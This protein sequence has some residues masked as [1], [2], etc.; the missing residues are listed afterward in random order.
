[1]SLASLDPAELSAL[2]ENALDA[3]ISIDDGGKIRFFNPAAEKLFQYSADELLGKSVNALMRDD[4]AASHDTFLDRYLATGQRSIIGVGRAVHCRR[5]DGSDFIAHIWIT[6]YDAADGKRFTAVLHDLSNRMRIIDELARIRE[7]LMLTVEN[8]PIGIVTLDIRGRV[9]SM[10]RWAARS[11]GYDRLELL[12]QDALSFMHVDDQQ[13]IRRSM[14]ALLT[15]RIDHSISTH[16]MR[17]ANRDYMPVQLYIA[18]AHDKQGR[19]RQLICM[20]EDLTRQRTAEAEL[21]M[22]RERLAHIARIDT[23]GEMAVG[24]AHEL[25]QPLAAITTYT[26]AAKRMFSDAFDDMPELGETCDKIADQA[27]RA[28][29]IIEKLRAL[30]RRQA[31]ERQRV[32]IPALIENLKSLLDIDSRHTGVRIATE[33]DA[34]PMVLADPVQIEQVILNFTRNAVDAVRDLDEER[35]T[36]TIRT[37]TDDSGDAC[38]SVVDRGNGV[39]AQS[40]ARLFDAF[41]TTKPEGMGMGLTIS[42][43]L[44]HAHH[45]EIGYRDNPDGGAEFWFTL[46]SAEDRHGDSK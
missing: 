20:F 17:A 8:A 1:M 2:V 16:Q 35:K 12:G 27:R 32:A 33:L 22:Q 7:E 23:M 43:T 44:I 40:R 19:P 3:I 21:Q 42:R 6:E 36:V 29:N 24:L 31:T 15:R 34:V 45:G 18:V 13:H 38:L 30:T 26:H 28:S 9:L 41:F 46:P 39:G 25:N 14:R 11:T 5:K 10:N 37:Y 4:D